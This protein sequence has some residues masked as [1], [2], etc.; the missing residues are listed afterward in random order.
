M[1]FVC[2]ISRHKTW[3]G[4]FEANPFTLPGEPYRNRTCHLLIK[5]RQ[6]GVGLISWKFKIRTNSVR[7]TLGDFTFLCITETI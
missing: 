7:V 3:A 6:I 5:S 2:F 1:T 4:L